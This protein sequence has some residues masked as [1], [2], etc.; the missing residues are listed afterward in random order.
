LKMMKMTFTHLPTRA[1]RKM[2]FRARS[3][4]RLQ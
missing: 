1:L 4:N 2:L 3:R